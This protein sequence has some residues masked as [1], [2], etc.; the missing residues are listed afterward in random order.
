MMAAAA[1]LVMAMLGG[2][3]VV[4]RRAVEPP[5]QH[6]PM[7]VVIADFD[8]RT[9]DPAFDR[10]ARADAQARA[11]RRGL[12]QRV[13]PERH[14]ATLGVRPPEKLDE[15]AARELAVK[16]GLGV[17]LSGRGRAAG[18]RLRRVGEGDADR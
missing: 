6:D 12:H 17:V 5:K 4:T 14:H 18:Q 1:L 3:Y 7:S 13:R 2:T 15:V 8:N 9:G 11:R 10:H 16:Q